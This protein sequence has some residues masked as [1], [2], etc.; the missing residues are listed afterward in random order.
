MK[1][2]RRGGLM[3]MVVALAGW[4]GGV[5]ADDVKALA[6]GRHLASECTS[7]H[8]ID[9]VDNGIPSII[10]WPKDVF[11]ETIKFYKDGAR[12]NAAM[13]SVAQSLDDEQLM[14]LALYFGTLPKPI[15]K[16]K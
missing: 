12:D 15:A 1:R 6:F 10:G 4:S 3:T 2:W 11:S 16:K 9:G 8:R 5:A 14:A 13:K 7:C